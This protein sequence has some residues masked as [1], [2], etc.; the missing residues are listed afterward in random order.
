MPTTAKTLSNDEINDCYNIFYNNID[1]NQLDIKHCLIP[2]DTNTSQVRFN[3]ECIYNS[4]QLIN[5]VNNV[6]TVNLSPLDNTFVTD[7][8]IDN[9]T[10]NYS[11]YISNVSVSE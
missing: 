9:Y 3:S 11:D 7:P 4:Y 1:N 6:Y 10:S 5:K 2:E 8:V